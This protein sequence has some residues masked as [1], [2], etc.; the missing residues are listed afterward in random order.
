MSRIESGKIQIQE[1]EV[2]LKEIVRDIENLIQPMVE[3]NRLKFCIKE[4]I[5]NNYVFCDKLRLNQV[6]I[7]LLGNAVKFTPEGGTVTLEIDQE[8]SAPEGYGIYFFKVSDTG[9]GIAKEFHNKIFEAFERE[10]ITEQ[11]GI[12][13]TGLGLAIT[14]NIIEMMGGRISVESEV[15]E[16]TTFIVKVMFALQDIDEE[17]LFEDT[18]EQR[19]NKERQEEIERKT[20]FKNQKILL[21]EDNTLNREIA[22][23]LLKEQ[24]FIVEEAV[25]GRE[26]VDKLAV[27][28][29]GEYALVLMDIQM[30]VMDGYEATKA[31]RNMQNRVLAH[32]PIIAM[33]ANAFEEEKKMALSCGMNGH[34]SKP[35]DINV[36]F[37][38]IEGIMK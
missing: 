29:N 18:L 13:G 33:T 32:T 10:R 38:T 14:K 22:R 5:V 25:N 26:A 6:L 31:I 4:S 20:L 1:D 27:A 9:I 15:G 36:L 7:N 19:E 30:P 16:G 2:S 24:G 34:V 37:K 11:S 12:Q 17:V 21:V 35:I 28:K 8:M 3:E 23:I